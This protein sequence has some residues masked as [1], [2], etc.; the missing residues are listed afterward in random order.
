MRDFMRV[1]PA[2]V[3][4]ASAIG[5]WTRLYSYA[6]EIERE[7]V[8]PACAE[9]DDRQWLA[10]AHLTRA[11]VDQV[12]ASA[13]A[14]FHG[15][16]LFVAGYDLDGE[17]KVRLA[18]ENGS[19]P[20]RE[21]NRRRGRPP[22]TDPKP[23]GNP[24][25]NRSVSSGKT[26]PKPRE[27]PSAS[28]GSVSDSDPDPKSGRER[29]P[30]PRAADEKPDDHRATST[31]A[32]ELPPTATWPAERWKGHYGEAW[33]KAKGRVAYGFGGTSDAKAVGD[34][35]E[36]L[37]RL[38]PQERAFAQQKAG[39]IF[40]AFLALDGEVAEAEHRWSWFV[41][42]FD[43]LLTKA[44]REAGRAKPVRTPDRP[45][46]ELPI[47]P[48]G[49]PRPPMPDRPHRPSAPDVTIGHFRQEVI[50]RKSQ[51]SAKL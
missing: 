19:R 17:R 39:A 7:G 44:L 48:R 9:F 50:E 34:M 43:S 5:S 28:S 35:T 23:S 32:E 3:A 31:K 24:K 2:A 46:N 42:R 47:L 45:A 41:V 22:K 11:E 10:V 49:E 27:N 16:D 51:R 40:A 8:I 21:G 1:A 18:R 4:S 37:G 20:V 26:Q 14:E 30:R 36:I 15:P 38:A 13:L 29:E 6:A 25:E 12:V 33:A